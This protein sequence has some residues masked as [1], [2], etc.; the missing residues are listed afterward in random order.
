MPQPEDMTEEDLLDEFMDLVRT[1]RNCG[2]W[3]RERLRLITVEVSDLE[4]IVSDEEMDAALGS[5]FAGQ[6]S[7][8]REA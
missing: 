2:T 1:A 6:Y 5:A 4:P 7:I 8:G 3:D